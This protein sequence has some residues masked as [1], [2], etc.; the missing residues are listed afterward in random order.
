MAIGTEEYILSENSWVFPQ[1]NRD[2]E[3]QLTANLLTE[4]AI[5]DIVNKSSSEDSYVVDYDKSKYFIEFVIYGRTFKFTLPSSWTNSSAGTIYAVLTITDESTGS[6]HILNADIT[7]NSESRYHGIKFTN[8]I[9][10]HTDTRGNFDDTDSGIDVIRYYLKI[11]VD[12]EVPFDSWGN[13]ID[14][15]DLP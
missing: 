6:E 7:E 11:L 3:I 4:Q 13:N 9:T 2:Q 8:S 12:G 15:G 1:A 5:S 10:G 14:C